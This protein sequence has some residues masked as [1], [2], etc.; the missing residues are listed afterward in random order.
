MTTVGP[1]ACAG[2]AAHRGLAFSP[3]WYGTPAGSDQAAAAPTTRSRANAPISAAS[4]AGWSSGE[5]V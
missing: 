5:N 4:R 1:A 3:G 2:A